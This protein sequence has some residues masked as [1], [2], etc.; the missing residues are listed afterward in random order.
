MR[1]DIGNY[2][3]Y[4]D[5]RIYSKIS[6]RFLNPTQTDTGYLMLGSGLGS[7]HR[8]VVESFLGEIPKGLVVN[9]IDGN[10]LNNRLSNLEVVTYSEN[11]KHAYRLGLISTHGSNNA[12]SKVVEEDV[13]LMYDM[14]KRGC[15]NKEVSEVFGLHDRYISLIRHG[16][17][18]SV[19]YAEKVKTPFIKSYNYKY[20][21]NTLLYARNLLLSGKTNIEVSVE[22]GIEKSAVSRLKSG[23][24]YSGFFKAYDS[25]VATTIE[26][27]NEEKYFV[28]NRVE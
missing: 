8:L 23:K 3:V 24:L 11:M 13:L 9:H 14:F 21:R 26:R 22:T 17:R 19:L 4:S 6:E 10:K 2:I 28:E 25:L 12:M 5:G 16:K 1:K 18:W 27:G 7:V 20:D 15:S